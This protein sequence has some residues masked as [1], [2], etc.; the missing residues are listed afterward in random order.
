MPVHVLVHGLRPD[1]L[2]KMGMDSYFF[3]K[4]NPSLITINLNAYGNKGPW[5]NRR[6]FDSLVQMSSGIA[7]AGAR[8]KNSVKPIPLPMQALDYGTGYLMAASVCR[9]LSD[10][11]NKNQL[12]RISA[13]LIG[14][15]NFLQTLDGNF[16]I[17]SPKNSDF[18]SLLIHDD[19]AFGPGL[20]LPSPATINGERA[21]W[22]IQAGP[23]GVDQPRFG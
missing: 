4:L 7:E 10:L 18:D 17:D 14:A 21:T 19:T 2:E 13:S 6:G 23:L 3:E 12:Y 9:S 22:S 5:K 16:E 15:S 8:Y 1:A 20:R 11:Y